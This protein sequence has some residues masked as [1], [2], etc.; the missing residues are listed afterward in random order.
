MLLKKGLIIF[1][2]LFFVPIAAK[3]PDSNASNSLLDS[4][5]SKVSK[6]KA[7]IWGSDVIP[8]AKDAKGVVSSHIVQQELNT[9][10]IQFERLGYTGL[11][12]QLFKAYFNQKSSDDRDDIEDILRQCRK[13]KLYHLERAFR[14]GIK[15]LRKPLVLNRRIKTEKAVWNI[16]QDFAQ[17]HG[18]PTLNKTIFKY[19]VATVLFA[20][21]CYFGETFHTWSDITGFIRRIFRICGP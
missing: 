8:K 11:S 4:I 7:M 21:G 18:A 17:V 2:L 15:K 6:A 14:Y 19:S 3:S 9:E 5:W 12:K 1:I 13:S 16:S 20:S 10:E